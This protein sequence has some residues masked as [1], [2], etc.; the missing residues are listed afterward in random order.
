MFNRTKVTDNLIGLVGWKQPINPDYI[1]L[2][3]TNLQSDSDRLFNSNSFV[4]PELLKDNDGYVVRAR[5]FC[6]D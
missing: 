3:A 5:L 2:D 1:T 4:K 6:V